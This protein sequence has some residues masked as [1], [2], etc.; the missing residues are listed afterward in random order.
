MLVHLKC[1]RC[2]NLVGCTIV[3]VDYAIITEFGVEGC[4]RSFYEMLP[5]D[6]FFLGIVLLILCLVRPN[7]NILF[8]PFGIKSNHSHY[9]F[10]S[11]SNM[12]SFCPSLLVMLNIVFNQVVKSDFVSILFYGSLVQTVIVGF[13]F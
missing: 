7:T 4:C 10:T 11:D 6:T 5:H 13:D 12:Q 9:L 2:H 3:E 1:F 8:G